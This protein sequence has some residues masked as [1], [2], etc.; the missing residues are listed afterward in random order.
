[1]R[2]I[3]KTAGYDHVLD[4]SQATQ[5]A[6]PLIPKLSPAGGKASAISCLTSFARTLPLLRPSFRSLPSSGAGTWG[7]A[8]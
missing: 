7:T 1:M 8:L 5:P 6:T 3:H 4:D 2:K